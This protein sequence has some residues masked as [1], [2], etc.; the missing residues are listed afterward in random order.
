MLIRFMASFTFL[1]LLTQCAFAQKEAM[2][3][4]IRQR[5]QATWEIAQKIWNLAEPG[6]QE[7]ES[8]KLLADQLEKVGFHVERGVADIPTAFTATFGT[9]KPVIAILGEYDALPGLS[10]QAVPEQLPRERATYGH[11]C[12]H[13][14]FGTASASAA[15]AVAEQIKSGNLS[16][17]IRF[18]GCPAEE[19]GSGKTCGKVP[20]SWAKCT[21]GRRTGTRPFI[22]GRHRVGL[23]CLGIAA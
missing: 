17:T 6:Y 19:G 9:G 8:A 2:S 4:S 15:I 10:Q 23:S 18:Y 20:V 7:I 16:G 1:L 3:T 22:A 13:H 11:A 5:E 12:G 21:R 14:L